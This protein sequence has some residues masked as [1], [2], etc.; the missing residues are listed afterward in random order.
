MAK[1]CVG[2]KLKFG[3]IYMEEVVVKVNNLKKQY[4]DV[5][6]V[7][8]VSFHVKKKEIV[9]ILGPNG[10][11]KTTTLEI[12]EGLRKRDDGEIYYFGEK[13]DQIDSNIKEKIG[14]QL[15]STVFF[16]NL[17]VVETLKAFA[18]LYQKSLDVEKVI[19]DFNL[20]EKK[21]SRISKLSG[22]QLQRLALATAVINDP[23][24]VFLDEPTTGLDPQA[25][26]NTWQIISNL[27][28]SGKTIIL[29]THY[30]E[31]AE[32][33][34][35][36]VYIFDQG[37]IIAQGTVNKLVDSLGMSSIISFKI[38]SNGNF[39]DIKENLFSESNLKVSK[40]ENFYRIEAIDLENA[41]LKIFEEARMKKFDISDMIIRKPNLEDV[42]LKLT[43]KRLRD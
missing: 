39:D 18:G 40:N 1:K 17:T 37:Q 32:F 34:A 19:T 35:D 6:A 23:D 33:L 12:L 14:V 20:E 21:R 7:N 41:L 16:Q 42:F 22:G 36:R 30:M 3:G 9:A 24:I 26:R 10:A 15:Q 43:G 4:K 5:K 31:E 29:T 8:D 28:N 38:N 25:R 27:R 2:M 13:V 11:G